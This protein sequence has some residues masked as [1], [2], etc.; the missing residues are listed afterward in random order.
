MGAI[1]RNDRAAV[2]DQFLELIL[3]DPDF[4]EAA[5]ASVVA[6]F[7]ATPPQARPATTT[8]FRPPASPAEARCKP[9]QYRTVLSP[10]VTPCRLHVA[11][12]PPHDSVRVGRSRQTPGDGERAGASLRG[13]GGNCLCLDRRARCSGGAA[14][15]TVSR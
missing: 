8:R 7:E 14:P 10:S 2:S 9:S 6:S 3:A 12:S 11:R 4:L 1:T 13:T 15:N 5:F